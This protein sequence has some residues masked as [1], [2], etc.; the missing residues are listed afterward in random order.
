M[1]IGDID[2]D[3]PE[4]HEYDSYHDRIDDD[5]DTDIGESKLSDTELIDKLCH[6]SNTTKENNQKSHIAN[7]LEWEK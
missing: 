2:T 3:K 7:E 6:E 5:D 1:D 4:S